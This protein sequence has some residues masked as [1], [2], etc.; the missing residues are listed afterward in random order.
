MFLQVKNK[1]IDRQYQRILFRENPGDPIQMFEPT[2]HVFGN[3]GSPCI[4]IFCI[5]EHAREHEHLYP[6]AA[7]AVINSSIVDDI[8]DSVET[9]SEAIR[10]YK[11]LKKLFD[12][13]GMNI[14]NSC[15]IL[16]KS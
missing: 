1:P 6:R 2:V 3:A 7:E 14:R 12:G 10:L 11:D 16:T 5:T 9:E 4:A 8:M 15:Q 13:C